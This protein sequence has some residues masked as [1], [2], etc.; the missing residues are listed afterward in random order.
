MRAP[1]GYVWQVVAGKASAVLTVRALG[2]ASPL[3]RRAGEDR[4]LEA[5]CR[6]LMLVAFMRNSFESM[7]N[8]I[9]SRASVIDIGMPTGATAGAGD[10]G[11]GAGSGAGIANGLKSVMRRPFFVR[12]QRR[13]IRDHTGN[14]TSGTGMRPDFFRKIKR[15][16]GT[17]LYNFEQF[18]S[19]GAGTF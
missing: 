1:Y 7:R 12:R 10:A 14:P 11:V 13:V 15:A 3:R 8:R 2:G 18:R 6:S 9:V 17:H 19:V 4:R 16:R 5:L